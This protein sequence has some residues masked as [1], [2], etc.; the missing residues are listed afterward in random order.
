MKAFYKL[1]LRIGI[2]SILIGIGIAMIAGIGGYYMGENSFANYTYS[3]E[4]RIENVNVT[5]LKFNIDYGKVSIKEG[6]EFSVKI[7]NMPENGY[8]SYVDGDTWIIETNSSYASTVQLFGFHIP[9]NKTIWK[10]DNQVTKIYITIPEQFEAENLYLKLG[11]GVL[12]SDGLKSKYG[13]I[14][15]GAGQMS[16][17]QLSISEKATYSVGAGELVIS[18]LYAQNNKIDCAVG[19]INIEGS[20]F[21][22]NQ[23]QCGIG[24][25]GLNLT[26][27][28]ED[29]NYSISCGM[30]NVSINESQFGPVVNK[31]LNFENA[32]HYFDLHCAIGEINLKIKE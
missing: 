6:N 31:E 32:K 30:G 28:K 9:V 14:S 17:N 2:G 16:L 8:K 29:Y 10:R 12:E 3:L 7:E 13:E 27:I 15:V 5:S 24:K 18:N 1:W 21:G 19:N 25:I 26:G 20:M 4:D 22:S 23:I 11:A